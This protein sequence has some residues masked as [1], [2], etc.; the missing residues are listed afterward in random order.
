M[1]ETKIVKKSKKTKHTFYVQERFSENSAVYNLIW[2]NMVQP[3]RPQMTIFGL[4]RLQTHTRGTRWRSWLG[5]CATNQ[6]V[7]GSISD[8]TTGIFH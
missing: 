2:K 4:I 8:D 5:H 3:D 6:K 7:A 1:F